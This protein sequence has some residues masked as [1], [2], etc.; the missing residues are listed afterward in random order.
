MPNTPTPPP[1]TPDLDPRSIDGA[2]PLLQAMIQHDTVTPSVSGRPAAEHALGVFLAGIAEPWGLGAEFLPVAGH[3]PNVLLTHRVDAALPWRL[4]DSHLD[5]VGV[6]GMTV[7]PFG[8]E[9]RDGLV[10]GRGACDTKGTGAAMLWAAK[11]AIAAGTLRCN[12]AILLTVGEE[13]HQIGAR[14]F[15]EHNLATLGWRP[16]VVVVGEPTAMQA[17][18]ASNGFVRWRITTH[19]KAA[20]SSTP[21]RGRNAIIDMA[22]VVLAIESGH[23]ARLNG[24]E[25]RTDPRTGRSTCSINVVRGGVQHNIVP[26]FCEVQVDQRLVPGH[27]AE[28]VLASVRSDLEPMAAADPGFRYTFKS[29]ESAKPFASEASTVV[30]ERVAATLSSAGLASEVVGAP[31]TTNANHYAPAGL[32]CVVC[33]PGDIAKAHTVDES[34]AV[35]QLELGVHGYRALMEAD[36]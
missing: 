1:T 36:W 2:V 28:E 27:E 24:A 4:F 32:P 16:E 33:G 21:E 20:H 23:I 25:A 22:R 12:L 18:A 5:T 17:V 10:L 3:A 6:D 19:G 29:I 15:L 14:A 9:L 7:D 11:Q 13:Q 30:S 8:G 26:D 34:I 31:Y 35:E